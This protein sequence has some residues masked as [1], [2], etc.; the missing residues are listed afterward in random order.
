MEADLDLSILQSFTTVEE[1]A[2]CPSA[3][4]KTLSKDKIYDLEI[5]MSLS[6]SLST[7]NIKEKAKWF[8]KIIYTF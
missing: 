1:K 7:L 2:L 3:H 8:G 4:S 5:Y 6:F